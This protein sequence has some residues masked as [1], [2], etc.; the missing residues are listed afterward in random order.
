[1]GDLEAELAQLEQAARSQSADD[2]AVDESLHL[3]GGRLSV[4]LVLAPISSPEALHSLLGL[5]GI[6]ESVV[7]LKPWTG[8]W[9]R[10]ETVPTD[11]DSLEELLAD[12]RPMPDAVDRVARVV[13]RL[14]KYGAVALMSWLVEGEGVEP[15]VSGKIT[16]QRYVS[17]EPEEPI[18]AG[19]LLGSMPQAT[20]DLLLGRTTPAD[21]DDSV[22]ADGIR[23][24]PGG[25]FGWF[26]RRK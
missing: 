14:S 3:E 19:L 1:M 2:I 10:V 11:E 4:A 25:P 8:V 5:T 21:Y 15:G 12:V 16:A 13:S 24:K 6:R 9:L 20:E 22:S 17:G 7:R 26:M 23:R 18:P